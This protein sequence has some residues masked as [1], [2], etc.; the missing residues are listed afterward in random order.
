MRAGL[1]CWFCLCGLLFLS[2]PPTCYGQGV[3]PAPGART[4]HFTS[5]LNALVAR[6]ALSL[7]NTRLLE[8]E[9]MPGLLRLW[10][11]RQALGAGN[12][13][14]SNALLFVME[15]NPEAFFSSMSIHQGVF[16]EWIKELPD[17]SFTWASPPPCELEAKR[18]QLILILEHTQVRGIKASHLKDQMLARLSTIRCRQ[19]E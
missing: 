13:D 5:E 19:I 17:L 2:G 11:N 15:E 8:K 3:K 16:A 14:L 12:F 10:G 1:F 4:G 18:K 9:T 7:G 6:A